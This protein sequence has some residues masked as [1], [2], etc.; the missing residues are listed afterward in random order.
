[1]PQLAQFLAEVKGYDVTIVDTP[2]SLQKSTAAALTASDWVLVPLAPEEFS[3]NGL[4]HLVRSVEGVR[5]FANPGL[6]LLGYLLSLYDVR[7][8]VHK[9][10]EKALRDQ[11]GDQVFAQRVPLASAYKEAIARR[12]P[13]TKFKPRSVAAE[14]FRA[15]AS[16]IDTRVGGN[17]G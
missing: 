15:L 7:L 8:S 4:I 12:L 17:H 9:A 11:Y 3:A 6:R 1:M 10:Y 13:I 2:P 14:A 5:R 16:E